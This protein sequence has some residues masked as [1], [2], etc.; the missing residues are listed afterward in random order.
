MT[1]LTRSDLKIVEEEES[2]LKQL[3]EYARANAM[4]ESREELLE[5]V[6]SVREAL[7]DA[8]EDEVAQLTE[9]LSRL[10]SLVNQT[11]Q[12]L[13][14]G[15]DV[16]NPYFAHMRLK[17][18]KRIRNIFI[19]TNVYCP[20]NIPFQIVDWK[21]SP[22]SLLYYRYEEGE[23]YEEEIGGRIFDGVV[24]FKR[25][26]KISDGE[27]VRIAQGDMV[28]EKDSTGKWSRHSQDEHALHGGAGIAPRAENLRKGNPKMGVGLKQEADK[29]KLLKEI[30]GLIDSEQF[31]LITKPKSGV[32]AIQGTAGSG[33]TTVAL[34]RVA[35]LH[36]QD[37]NVFKP[38]N[39][40]VVVFSKALARYISKVL[41]SLGVKNVNIHIFEDW[42][43]QQRRN[44]FGPL[45]PFKYQEFTPVSVIRF[46]KHP[47]LLNTI[48]IFLGGKETAFDEGLNEIIRSKDVQGFPVKDFKKIPFV[49]RLYIMHKWV[50][51]H[52]QFKK[53][54]F[55]YGAEVKLLMLKLMDRFVDFNNSGIE[56][57]VQYWDELFS[58]FTYLREHYI[59][60]AEDDFSEV[61]FKEI[62]EWLK[63]QYVQRQSTNKDRK[64]GLMVDEA[65]L[66]NEDDPILLLFYQ[67]LLGKGFGK[68]DKGL[69]KYRHLMIDEAQDLCALELSVM[70][71]MTTEPH[72]VT[73]A[74]D[75]NQK[76]IEHGGFDSWER[77][78]N[79]LGLEG[80][81][82]SALKV[83]YR[84]TY[85]I[86]DFAVSVLEGHAAYS[87]EIKAK[88][89][90]PPV[91]F[92]KY[93]NQGEMLYNLSN[94]LNTLTRQEPGASVALI[95]LTPEAAKS[96]Y[97]QLDRMEVAG[98]RWV[99]DQDFSF[100][101]GIDVTD[102]RQ[103][104]GLEFDYVVLM[105]VDTINYPDNT[106]ARYLLHI[107][108]T[109][110]SHQ[111]WMMNYR[112]PSH[113]IPKKVLGT[114]E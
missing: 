93:D 105:D 35:W 77:L 9:Q 60:F 36:Y 49:S 14:D 69:P 33:K 55:R 45:L 75:V 2:T 8:K 103:V 94:T 15:V 78:F 91:E 84:S 42:M 106:Y 72:S 98:I 25:I 110:A 96:Y 88:R 6:Y 7:S 108:A 37:P 76:L 58:D 19:G 61:K 46:K 97:E 113:L 100:T 27:L 21:V 48:K 11:D 32:V 65:S 74:G 22:I 107:G 30:T 101:A 92:F 3:V 53:K 20:G 43:S 10:M 41:P 66:D 111:L 112:L 114:V 90:G 29:T 99:S 16:S 44:L 89:N 59:K 86:M 23:E 1:E 82:V 52:K 71:G 73:L 62:T 79:D 50:S 31:S 56:T 67:Q 18:A 26:I 39:M 80:E 28:L 85:E 12:S 34:H 47:A 70:M 63:K 81:E 54:A 17:E 68:T 4:I 104:K 57:V 102:I 13:V 109:R 5:Q 51:G 87:K 38:K 24:E 95:C 40:A 64:D 83:S